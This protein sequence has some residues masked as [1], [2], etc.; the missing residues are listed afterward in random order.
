MRARVSA[1]GMRGVCW[2]TGAEEGVLAAARAGGAD[3]RGCA[4]AVA[5][6]AAGGGGGWTAA[7]FLV[8]PMPIMAVAATVTMTNL[9]EFFIFEYFLPDVLILLSLPR[10]TPS[11]PDRISPTSGDPP[12]IPAAGRGRR[13][14]V[15]P[16]PGHVVYKAGASMEGTT[17]RDA[18][19]SCPDRILRTGRFDYTG[20]WRRHGARANVEQPGTAP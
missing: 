8:H 13:P 3:G 6:A 1:L 19:S 16:V 14:R 15:R 7:V 2:A 4:A 5:A 9:R 18:I 11:C 20:N 12:P 10:Q 17:G